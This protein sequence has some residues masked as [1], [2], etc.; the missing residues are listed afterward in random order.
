MP[1]VK[2]G[3]MHSKRRKNVLARTKGFRWGRKSKISLARTATM[4]A[5]QFAYKSRKTQKRINRGLW[6]ININ[7]AVRELGMS[8]SQ[9][10]GALKKKG[11]LLNRKVLAEIGRTEPKIMEKIAEM[12]K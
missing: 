7:A 3:M 5:G 10:M 4:K 9:F 12:A 11:V 8:Y 2:R 1:R 6:L